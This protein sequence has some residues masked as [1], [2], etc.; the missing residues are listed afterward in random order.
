VANGSS[1]GVIVL[2]SFEAVVELMV[3]RVAAARTRP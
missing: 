1:E 3:A 2:S